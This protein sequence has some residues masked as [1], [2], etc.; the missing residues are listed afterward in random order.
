M[1]RF[2]KKLDKFFDN[3]IARRIIILLV[4]LLLG[5]GIIFGVFTA[6]KYSEEEIKFDDLTTQY[7]FINSKGEFVAKFGT[8]KENRS[9]SSITYEI[10]G[11]TLYIT[12]F[13]TAGTERAVNTDKNGL[14]EFT[15]PDCKE[16]KNVYY[17]ANGE[18]DKIKLSK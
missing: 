4:S 3:D 13:H 6:Y 18:E 11:D 17:V 14:A 7:A 10:E 1:K 16:I 8:K 5:A 9:L 2:L 15:I 12:V